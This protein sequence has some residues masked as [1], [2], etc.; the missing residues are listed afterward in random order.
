MQESQTIHDIHKKMDSLVHIKAEVL[1]LKQTIKDLVE[2]IQFSEAELLYQHF[3]ETGQY[4]PERA[5]WNNEKSNNHP[6]EQSS[7]TREL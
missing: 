3:T 4:L 1:E 7:R 6:K 5:N 2:V